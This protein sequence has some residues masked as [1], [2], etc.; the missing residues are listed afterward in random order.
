MKKLFGSLIAVLFCL[1]IAAVPVS[2][3]MTHVDGDDGISIYHEH[4]N[5]NN[6]GGFAYGET[7]NTYDATV[8][9]QNGA[10]AMGGSASKGKVEGNSHNFGNL[11]GIS[12]SGAKVKSAAGTITLP[13]GKNHSTVYGYV[14]Q[15]NWADA[16]AGPGTWVEG[17]NYS[18]AQ[19]EGDDYGYI[20][21]G[22][23][24][25]AKT[26]GLTI[27]GAYTTGNAS[28]AGGMTTNSASTRLRHADCGKVSIF[29]E[30]SMNS[31][32]YATDSMNQSGGSAGTFAHS[33]F[34]YNAT[35]PQLAGGNGMAA[36][37]GYSSVTVK[38]HSVSATSVSAGFASSNSHSH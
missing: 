29:G 27:T 34:E 38:P 5:G 17:G 33:S 3:D 30:G 8:Y 15:A 10:F 20:H 28:I 31:A 37:G 22:L 14:E 19:Y 13:Y 36:N 25:K 35:G 11:V 1:A 12:H 7:N 6:D 23:I 2:A 18:N 21:S 4:D 9:G 16:E 24:G 32:T 26:E